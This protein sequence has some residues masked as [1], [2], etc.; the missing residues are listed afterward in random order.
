MKT[1][2]KSNFFP[3]KFSHLLLKNKILYAKER[4]IYQLLEHCEKTD[5]GPPNAYRCTQKS[6]AT[7]FPKKFIP[8]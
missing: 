1:Q 6:H 2:Q 4:S 7:L 3:L 5:R 8:F